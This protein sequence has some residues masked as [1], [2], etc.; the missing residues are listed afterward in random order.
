MGLIFKRNSTKRSRNELERILYSHFVNSNPVVFYNFQEKEDYIN[1]G[2]VHNSDVYTIIK[3]IVDTASV[4]KPYIYIDKS[5][6]KSRRI[7]KTSKEAV[8]KQKLHVHKNLDFADS[9]NDLVKLIQ[10]PN[11]SQTWTDLSSLRRIFYFVQGEQ[12]MY[13][14]AGDDNCAISL[15]TVPS[16]KVKAIVDDYGDITDW[17]IDIGFQQKRTIPAEDVFFMG[18]P[19][20]VFDDEGGQLRGMSPLISGLKHLQ[21]SDKALEAWVKSV[22][23]EGA[24]GIVSPNHNNPELWLTPEQVIETEG[25]VDTK[26]HGLSNKNK[27]VVSGMPLQYT[28][29]GLS[30]QAMNVISGLDNAFEKLCNIWGVPP[31]LFNPNPTYDNQNIASERFLKEVI[32]PYLN[33]EEDRLNQWLVEPFRIRDNKEYVLDYDL[34]DYDALKLK[35][36]EIEGLRKILSTNEI[37][38]LAGYDENEESAANEI[39]VEAGLI[40][41]SDLS[42]TF[43]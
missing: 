1:R 42:I 37:R 39:L 38:I 6:V 36:S 22:E 23:N 10:H 21:L 13:R 12:L 30:P 32:L 9:D 25:K 8:L 2:Y 7:E 5:G 18:M 40:P 31:A 26:I 33:A 27:V 16:N 4:A 41:M 11:K 43:D 29:I 35:N 28:Q 24:K 20:P 14:E 19:N 3:K 34:S 15:H 17:S